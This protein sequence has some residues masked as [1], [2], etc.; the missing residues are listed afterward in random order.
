MS[1]TAQAHMVPA[2]LALILFTVIINAVDTVGA[3][4]SRQTTAVSWGDVAVETPSVQPGDVLA[5]TFTAR[6]NK[7]CPADLRGFLVAPDGSVP[8]RFPIVG[9]SYTKPSDG[10]SRI[11]VAITIPDHPDPGLAPFVAG[12]YVY[13]TVAT[14]YCSDGVEQD[15]S[16]PDVPFV[17]ALPPK[18]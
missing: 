18:A 1:R 11:R 9:G 16:I 8:V 10:P 17:L 12:R 4:V 7:Q 14:R 6:I 5:M 15:T 3:W 2:M 13:R